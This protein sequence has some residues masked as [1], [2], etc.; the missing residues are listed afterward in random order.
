MSLLREL[1]AVAVL[2]ILVI[3]APSPDFVVICR[4]SLVYSRRAGIY[5]AFGLALGIL[6][7]ASYSLKRSP[8]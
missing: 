5:S 1:I 3:V 4:N 6:V 2:Q 7:H 8:P